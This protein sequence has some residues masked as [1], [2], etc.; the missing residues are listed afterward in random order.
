M[1]KVHD[2][3]P[4]IETSMSF[5]VTCFRHLGYF[6][7]RCKKN[8]AREFSLL[9]NNEYPNILHVLIFGAIEIILVGLSDVSSI[10]SKIGA[11]G[12]PVDHS[13]TVTN[14]G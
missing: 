7:F 2:H 5:M 9:Q 10:A 3:W 12:T 11:L 8:R 13:V 6:I 14:Q 1:S 4:S